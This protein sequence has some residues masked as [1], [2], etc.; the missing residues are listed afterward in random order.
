MTPCVD[1]SISVEN[2]SASGGTRKPENVGV[3]GVALVRHDE[4]DI[5]RQS[6]PTTAAPIRGAT[7]FETALAHG[8]AHALV[9]AVLCGDFLK[10]KVLAHVIRDASCACPTVSWNAA[11]SREA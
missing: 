9:D 1:D 2:V 3:E 7:S 4:D 5:A 11:D 10:A 6:S 8:V